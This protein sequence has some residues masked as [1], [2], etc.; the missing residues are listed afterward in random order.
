MVLFC[1]CGGVEL[2]V[3]SFAKEANAG[4]AE[5]V[6][7]H[8]KGNTYAAKWGRRAWEVTDGSRA[9]VEGEGNVVT[10]RKTPSKPV[11]L[12]KTHSRYFS[13]RLFSAI[14]GPLDPLRDAPQTRPRGI[15]PQHDCLASK[16]DPTTSLRAMFESL[17]ESVSAFVGANFGGPVPRGLPALHPVT[18]LSPTV[19][20]VLGGNPSAF[21]LQGTN[22]YLIGT[23]AT[24]WLLDTGEGKPV[25]IT[26]LR[27]AMKAEGVTAL[28]GIL[29][30]H[31][32]LDHVGGIGD[33][34]ALMKRE[35]GAKQPVLAYKHVRHGHGEME[36]DAEAVI[37]VTGTSD[38]TER[39]N[40]ANEIDALKK[41]IEQSRSYVHVRDGDVFDAVPGVTL[42]AVFTPGHAEDH[43]C[44]VLEEEGSIFAGD[45]VLNGNTAV[46]ENLSQY[47]ASLDTMKRELQNAV[48]SAKNSTARDS[49]RSGNDLR[50][51][52]TTAS[53][54][55][56]TLYPS[57]GDVVVDGVKKLGV[58]A[59][60]RVTR[61]KAFVEAL[62]KSWETEPA[63]GGLT[64][65]ELARTVY[66][67][68]VNWLVLK[69]AVWGI[70]GQHLQKLVEDGRV[71][72]EKKTPWFLKWPEPLFWRAASPFL[73]KEFEI[74]W[75]RLAMETR[76]RPSAREMS[77]S[78]ST[79]AAT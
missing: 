29:L 79:S 56:G 49:N 68:S 59:K 65:S 23:G 60:H 63:R 21:T 43:F 5:R 8:G 26:N 61:E 33:V 75:E 31:W 27:A 44:F 42:R 7:E 19:V 69:T 54:P 18:R 30:T 64:Q 53:Q 41:T 16:R 58:Y 50:R 9:R 25:F 22:A 34:R 2:R 77:E 40:D 51:T 12:P 38:E 20:R 70:V 14:L 15:P 35:F 28:E 55:P 57:H 47:S 72:M 6:G 71:V 24:R 3:A 4:H 66:G 17:T 45:C 13:D 78:A 37:R 11:R 46:F 76:Y 67:N 74:W 73:A 32:H 10:E 62:V 36:V 48:A 52:S 1:F 39:G